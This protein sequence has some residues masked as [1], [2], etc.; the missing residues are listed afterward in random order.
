[1]AALE[2][3]R[4]HQV[5]MGIGLKCQQFP[6]KHF[7]DLSLVAGTESERLGKKQVVRPCFGISNIALHLYNIKKKYS[8]P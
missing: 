6:T 1:M 2:P 4:S 3:K 7:E 8:F 5:E